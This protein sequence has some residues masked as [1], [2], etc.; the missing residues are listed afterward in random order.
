MEDIMYKSPITIIQNQM[1]LK[2]EADI[3][4][5][6]QSCNIDVDKDELLKALKY[7]RDQYNK[8]YEDGK[9][10]FVDKVVEQLEALPNIAK[11]IEREEAIK[12]VKEGAK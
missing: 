6:V 3:L 10:E 2:M 8:G 9:R 4:K 12:I 11:L 7:D 5:A 1:E